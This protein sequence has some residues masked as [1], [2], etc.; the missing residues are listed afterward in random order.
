MPPVPS[1]HR[2]NTKTPGHPQLEG[3]GTSHRTG[4]LAAQMSHKQVKILLMQEP[5]DSS[6]D[7]QHAQCQESC[8]KSS[9]EPDIPKSTRYPAAN[10][11]TRW[12]K[13]HKTLPV[14]RNVSQGTNQCIQGR[15]C[16]GH[17]DREP[18]Q[19]QIRASG[20]STAMDTARKR[21]GTTPHRVPWMLREALR[22]AGLP[23]AVDPREML[24]LCCASLRCKDKSITVTAGSSKMWS[25]ESPVET[26]WP[27]SG[28]NSC[29]RGGLSECQMMWV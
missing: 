18:S 17:R 4:A 24:Y 12:R 9:T 13:V 25:G 8:C 11:I 29:P 21:E 2:C 23:S 5:Q 16:H 19:V 14:H 15:N 22:I 6:R 28:Q 1:L 27:R 3:Q 20:E 7:Q 26:G 10:S